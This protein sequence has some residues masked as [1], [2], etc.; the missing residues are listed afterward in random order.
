MK[1]KEM[2][3]TGLALVLLAYWELM[4]GEIPLG[5]FAIRYEDHA[6]T[7]CT[8][9]TLKLLLAAFLIS[10]A[11]LL[12]EHSLSIDKSNEKSS[13]SPHHPMNLQ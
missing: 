2:S 8:V 13:S 1:S 6:F 4:I 5:L 12:H 10:R 9:L 11:M 7:F 3:L